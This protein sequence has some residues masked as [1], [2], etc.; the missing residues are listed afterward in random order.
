MTEQEKLQQAIEAFEEAV[1]RLS[2]SLGAVS[3][4]L[5]RVLGILA[6]DEDEN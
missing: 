3:N 1:A 4:D 6:E 5:G 2:R